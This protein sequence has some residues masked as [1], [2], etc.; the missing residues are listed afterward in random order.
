M[1]AWYEAEDILSMSHLVVWPKSMGGAGITP[2]HGQ[3]QNVKSAFPM[4][5]EKVN[6][7]FLRRL[8]KKLLLGTD[9]LDKIRDL[10]GSK[11]CDT[12]PGV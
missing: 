8:G 11:V 9:D 4:H 3:W 5:N 1:T 2:G 10:F 7:A 6:Q 12:I